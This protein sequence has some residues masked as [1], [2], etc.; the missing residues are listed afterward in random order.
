MKIDI[1]EEGAART[2][3]NAVDKLDSVPSCKIEHLHLRRQR[4]GAGSE[5]EEKHHGTGRT[6]QKAAILVDRVPQ[7][8]V[9]LS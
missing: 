5:V 3:V 4:W 8:S 1:R 9:Y 6:V 2:L 7:T